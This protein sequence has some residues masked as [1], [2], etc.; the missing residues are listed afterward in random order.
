M[1]PSLAALAFL[2]LTL[3]ARAG[4]VADF[5]AA[6]DAAWASYRQALFATNA[7]DTAASARARNALSDQW[8]A[9]IDA[10]E[11][12]PPPHY[13]DD[14]GFADTLEQVA[15]LINKSS[16]QIVEGDLHGAHETLEG[17]RDE[18]AALHERNRIETF[19]DRMNA[20]HSMMEQVLRT[21]LSALDA[22]A[23]DRVQEDAALL[24][25][26]ARDLLSSPPPAYWDNPDFDPLSQAFQ[27]SVAAFQDAARSGD[28]QA[29]RAAAA[30]LKK[31]YA[32]LFL[33]FG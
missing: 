15:W 24:A 3:P 10:W 9:L 16:G 33:K 8:R 25:F 6:Y 22:A 27:A 4:P 13:A 23:I 31:P 20:Y 12:T 28:P 7:G 1:K 29:I 26:L 32:K 19:S 30:G 2:A 21:D 18:L 11:S 17:I 14:P 5:N